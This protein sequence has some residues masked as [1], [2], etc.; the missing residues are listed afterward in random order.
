M[1][2][3]EK[4]GV[5]YMGRSFD[6]DAG[7]ATA[8]PI[9]YDSKDLT[10]HAVIVGM[11][12]SGKTGL[13]IAMLEEAAIDGIPSII[14]DPKGDLGNLL[15]TFP[16]LSAAEFRPWIEHDEATRK[17]MTPDELAA[18]RASQWKQGLADWGQPQDR[19]QRFRDAVDVSIYT[20]GSDAGLSLT[21]LKSLEAPPAAIQQ[22]ADAMRERIAAAVG[23]LLTLL[24]RD[25][26]P[27]QSREHIFLSNI[28]DAAWRAGR[29]LDL[30]QLIREV[31]NPPFSQIGIMPVDQIF[32][33]ADRLKLAIT[34]NNVLASP[35][36]ASWTQGEP[37][38]IQRL[39]Y[40]ESGKPRMSILSIAHLNDHER[41]FFVTLLLTEMI[42]WMRQQPGTSSLRALLYMD[43]VFGYLPPTANPPSKV[44]MLTLLKQARAYGL[45]LVLATQNPV[46]LDYKAL[47]NAGTWF[48]GRL[49]TER[50]KARVLDGL[51]G[52]SSQAGALFDRQK[53]ERILSGLGNRVF[54][55]NNVHEDAPVV[56]QTR[57]ALSYLRG[58]MTRE[59][60]STLMAPR[61]SPATATVAGPIPSV[62]S[63]AAPEVSVTA[64]STAE[65]PPVLS[66]DIRQIYAVV[67]RTGHV[68]YRP[69]LL[70]TAS[71]HFVDARSQ[72]DV[73][74]N[75]ARLCDVTDGVPD[76][77]WEVADDVDPDKLSFTNQPVAGARFEIPP[78]AILQTKSYTAWKTGLKNYLYR[79][80]TLT[81]GYCESLDQYANPNES[82]SDFQARLKH[83]A[84]EE[85][86][87]KIEKLRKRYAPKM[88][89]L[90]ERLR[91]AQQAVEREK[92]QS[93]GATL[94]AA[95]QFGTSVLGA[96]FGRKLATSTN[97]NRAAGSVRSATRAA[98]QKGD[99]T[100]AQETSEAIQADL[101]A[102]EAELQLEIDRITEELD[103]ENLKVTEYAVKPRKSDTTIDAV[104]LMW[105][106]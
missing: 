57:W 90:D 24:D 93:S 89:T 66:S 18:D 76:D 51:E 32:P 17:G 78:A 54:L 84:R 1:Y 87:R 38:N 13:G 55:L 60:I 10:T 7:Q 82:L 92:A 100:R 48:L 27:L 34:I 81:V 56:F 58:P 30:P 19:I 83:A 12:G 67:S 105:L 80:V 26:D 4:L 46:D 15:L 68:G 16:G 6:I 73:W 99:V 45:G 98:E 33:A 88:T 106:A 61:K 63:A 95:V 2:D 69:A 11:T 64:S 85:R 102:L 104:S 79:A 41:M 44:P 29:S 77:P 43:E 49:Q 53:V 21:I 39:L 101:E 14:I 103:I 50:D 3:Y 36:F 42:A 35:A 86:D 74:K 72:V 28:L 94:T 9:L 25:A 8:N 20:P 65:Q 91:K 96:L 37:L 22:S 23:G 70:G 5:F 97:V 75:V 52:A 71:M 40:A 47:S 59:Q 31:Q 62:F